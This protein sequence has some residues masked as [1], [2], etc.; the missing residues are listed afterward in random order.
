[1]KDIVDVRTIAIQKAMRFLDS[2]GAQYKIIA[3]DGSEYGDLIVVKAA[4]RKLVYPLG[5]VRNYYKPMIENMKIGDVVSVP[6]GE[7][8]FV[9]IQ[10]GIGS[11]AGNHWGNSSVIT[12]QDLENNCVEVLRVA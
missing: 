9:R 8:G 5:A 11:F 4:K 3:A 12:R 6:I 2:V 1:M 7:Y 10:N